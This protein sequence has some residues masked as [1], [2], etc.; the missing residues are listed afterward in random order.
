L[1]KRFLPWS[2][3]TRLSRSAGWR[4][5]M[6]QR[7]ISSRQSG[8]RRRSIPFGLA[9]CHLPFVRPCFRSSADARLEIARDRGRRQ[10]TRI[11][12]C[13]PQQPFGASSNAQCKKCQAT[14]NR[15]ACA[16]FTSRRCRSP[17]FMSMP[18]ALQPWRRNTDLACR[19]ARTD[20]I[21]AGV[22]ENRRYAPRI[23]SRARATAQASTMLSPA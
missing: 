7:T 18:R 6:P 10:S 12:V 11:P 3:T 8:T 13:S 5:N 19:V 1:S 20:L 14:G 17:R 16:R 15:S 21:L 23:C 4:L 22:T 9:E 2:P